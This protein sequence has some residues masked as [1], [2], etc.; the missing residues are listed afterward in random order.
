M[1]RVPA[2]FGRSI[3]LVCT[4]VLSGCLVDPPCP[5]MGLER[6][7]RT[8][9]IVL[10]GNNLQEIATIVEKSRIDEIVEFALA[11]QEGWR[12]AIVGTPIEHLRANFYAQ[13]KFIGGLGVGSDFLTAQG[14]GRFVFREVSAA[15]RSRLMS[16]LA[17][18]DPYEKE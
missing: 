8:D 5:D 4:L 17:V 14:C 6:L 10:T 13:D 2:N 7:Q 3:I 1:Q 12:T 9:R 11:H 16:L 18:P 15:D